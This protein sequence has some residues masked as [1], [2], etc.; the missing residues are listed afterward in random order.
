MAQAVAFQALLSFV[1]FL[2]LVVSFWG[3]WL[4]GDE[5]TLTRI[6]KGL[7]LVLPVAV[8][9][10]IELAANP[11]IYTAVSVTALLWLAGSVFRTIDHA[12]NMAFETHDLR[13]PVLA[14]VKG[15]V[16]TFLFGLLLGLWV[17]WLSV[18]SILTEHLPPQLSRFLD[19]PVSTVQT[20]VIPILAL[21][22]LF[23]AL[24]HQLPHRSVRWRDA[25]RGGVLTAVLI[26]AALRLFGTVL[27]RTLSYNIL[28]GTVSALVAFLIWIYWGSCIFLYGASLVAVL[29]EPVAT[30][31]PV[32]A[33]R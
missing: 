31:G 32:A 4:G 3:H 23:T 6:S 1:P 24:Y 13:G 25:L 16:L 15:L 29:G 20:V 21:T 12:I 33:S 22:A 7:R 5:I 2:L 30:P 27:S 10:V 8:P 9:A 17:V 18:M 28:S 19:V 11:G 14:H 26:H